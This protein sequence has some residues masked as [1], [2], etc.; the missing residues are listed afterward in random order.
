[1]PTNPGGITRP[2]WLSD[3]IATSG[4]SAAAA[5]G[6]PSA[7]DAPRSVSTSAATLTVRAPRRCTRGSSHTAVA[8]RADALVRRG[9]QALMNGILHVH[10]AH[11]ARHLAADGDSA[12]A[13]FHSATAYD[14]V[15]GGPRHA[16][17]V[18]VAP[19]LDGDAIV[20]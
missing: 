10:V 13:V 16:A 7:R 12:V 14:D 17:A 15:R 2:V 18:A 4:A 1:M 20:A 11:S 6:W 9:R 5:R 19:G 8:G 3:T